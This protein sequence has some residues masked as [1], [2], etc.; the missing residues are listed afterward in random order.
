MY[1]LAHKEYIVICYNI[2][3]KYDFF[4]RS[5]LLWTWHHKIT[6][7]SPSF[8]FFVLPVFSILFLSSFLLSFALISIFFIKTLNLFNPHQK[9]FLFRI[10]SSPIFIQ[11]NVTQFT[12][13]IEHLSWGFYQNNKIFSTLISLHPLRSSI[14]NAVLRFLI[15]FKVST[16][17]FYCFIYSIPLSFLQYFSL[18]FLISQPILFNLELEILSKKAL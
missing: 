10:T 4:C 16:C 12:W 17:N 11:L 14:V 15:V 6:S 18:S 5:C 7:W 9:V 3:F 2:T 1:T 8:L 13:T